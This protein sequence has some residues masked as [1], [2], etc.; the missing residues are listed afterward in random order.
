MPYTLSRKILILCIVLFVLYLFRLGGY[1]DAFTTLWPY[2][3]WPDWELWRLVVYPLA[4]GGIFDLL[5][6]SITFS[7]PGEELESMLGTRGFG[8]LLL[9]VVL[10][11][12]LLQ[13]VLFWNEAIPLYG[14]IN[15]TVFT[16]IGFVYL[17]PQSD[18]RVIFF[19]VRSW[20]ILLLVATLALAEPI[21][22]VT[23]GGVTPWIMVTHGG[24]GILLGLA[25]FHARYQK[26]AVLLGPIRSIER[27]AARMWI[28]S[29]TKR[30]TAPQRVSTQQPVRIRIPFP[31][32][33][34]REMTDEERLNM[35]LDKINEK[36]YAALNDEERLFL[37][38]YSNRI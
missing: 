23:R 9:C 10:G 21:L 28:P 24:F 18:I 22:L 38:D 33:A 31:K 16:L 36:G 1:I 27:V 4:I 7:A 32:S 6:A 20:I 2:K 11:G 14:M 8:F 37:D 13:M 12:A 25:Y 15:P 26:Y 3:V 35:L 5:A 34:P 30:T 19:N 17:F 29:P